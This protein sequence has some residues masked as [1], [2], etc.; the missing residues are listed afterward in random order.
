MGNLCE[1]LQDVNEAGIYS[2]NCPLDELL[3]AAAQ[4]AL[5]LFDADLGAVHGKGEFLAVVAS[6]IAA[7]GWFGHNFDALADS[8]GD[9]SWQ[10][11][12]GY[13]LLLRN[14][15]ETFGMSVADHEI[16]AAILADSVSYWK[17]QGK[18]FWVFFF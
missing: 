9:L 15:S 12:P 17:S 14:G 3:G 5:A 6:A 11:A 4:S 13:V 18:P 8:L 2:L 10:P 1:R 16:A 7:P